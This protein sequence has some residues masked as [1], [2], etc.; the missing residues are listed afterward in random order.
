VAA[1]DW[2][3]VRIGPVPIL[4]NGAHASIRAPVR[5]C[6]TDPTER[7]YEELHGGGHGNQERDNQQ[8]LGH[9]GTDQ[10]ATDVVGIKAGQFGF[11]VPGREEAE[12]VSGERQVVEPHAQ[13]PAT[14]QGMPGTQDENGQHKHCGAGEHELRH[15]DPPSTRRTGRSEHIQCR[16]PANVEDPV[17]SPTPH[18]AVTGWP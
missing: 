10:L 2:S 4:L 14:Q 18:H 16:E 13:K 9:A 1:S 7:R 3:H 15:D 8:E 12:R 5:T 17:H 11:Q 6:A